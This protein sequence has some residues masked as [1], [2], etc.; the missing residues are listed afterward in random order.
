MAGGDVTVLGGQSQTFTLHFDTNANAQLA[1]VLAANIS[2]GIVDNSII[3]HNDSTPR[4]PHGKIGEFVDTNTPV[5]FLPKGYNAVVNVNSNATIFGSGGR[6][7]SVLSGASN[8]TFVARGGSG[9][10]VAGAGLPPTD[11]DDDRHDHGRRGG[12]GGNTLSGGNTIIVPQGD[13]G[14]WLIETGG[15]ND[16]IFARGGGND[17]I[18]AGPGHNLIRLGSGHDLVQ[19]SGN[20]TIFADG[21]AETVQ[22]SK[23]AKDLI[24]AGSSQ[25]TYIGGSGSA[26]IIGG[27]GKGDELRGGS[28]GKNS[29]VAG[30][31]NTTLFGGGDGDQMFGGSGHDTF[32]PA[33]GASTMT[34]GTGPDTFVFSSES[35]GGSNLIANFQHGMD[36][37][38][39][40]GYGSKAAAD[41][42][43]S[44]T[45]PTGSS[46]ML[47]LPDGTKVTF[48]DTTNIKLS[49]FNH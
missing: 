26:T 32:V 28:D 16:S 31:G 41:A 18:G 7:E 3:P 20:D 15:G 17:T 27:T 43:Q 46:T 33:Q 1:G 45:H 22:A 13:N 35:A 42:V 25:L 39:L 8:L 5:A 9:T 2:A 44:Q 37:I 29:I 49:D 38:D 12:V 34:A 40:Q 48:T 30:S 36:Q 24:F 11:S 6:G 14:N 47:T 10:V 23:G 4:L 21:G 19:S